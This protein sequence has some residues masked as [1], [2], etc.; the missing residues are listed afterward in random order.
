VN[1]PSQRLCSAAVGNAKFV[2]AR[3]CKILISLI[4]IFDIPEGLSAF[5]AIVRRHFLAGQCVQPIR[6]SGNKDEIVATGG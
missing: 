3:L 2:G 5:E 1:S 4:L 6:R